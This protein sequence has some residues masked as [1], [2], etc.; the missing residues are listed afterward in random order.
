MN[1]LPKNL[2]YKE[3]GGGGIMVSNYQDFAHKARKKLSPIVPN[4]DRSV[5]PL[6]PLDSRVLNVSEN[7]KFRCFET[8][9]AI[10]LACDLPPEQAVKEFNEAYGHSPPPLYFEWWQGCWEEFEITPEMVTAWLVR[11]NRLGWSER[12]GIVAAQTHERG[13]A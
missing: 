9:L 3:S 4:L 8:T 2:T 12:L 7:E 11:V 13:A 10:C 1:K 5:Y 6:N